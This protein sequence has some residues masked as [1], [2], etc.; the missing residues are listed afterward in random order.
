MVLKNVLITGG[1][2]YIGSNIVVELIRLGYSVHVID[3]LSNSHVSVLKLM[4]NYTQEK[5]PLW[6]LNLADQ[7][8]FSDLLSIFQCY[9]FDA[10]IHCAGKKF[11]SE[12]FSQ[13][14]SYYKTNVEGSLN[15][16]EAMNA[17]GVRNLIFSSSASIYDYEFLPLTRRKESYPLKPS[18]P[19]GNTKLVIENILKD[20]CMADDRWNIISLR[21]FN[22]VGSHLSRLFGES[23]NSSQVNLFSSLM[24]VA[25]G[26][27]EKLSVY[28]TDHSTPDGTGI[29]DYVHIT[30]LASAHITALQSLGK[31]SF[32]CL[33]YNVGTGMGWSV[34]DIVSLFKDILDI[35]V[36]LQFLPR[37]DGDPSSSIADPGLIKNDLGWESKLGLQ[38]MLI[39]H[40]EFSSLAN[41][42]QI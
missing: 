23:L 30:D 37:R 15:L 31:K 26:W 34:L 25:L 28:G 40:W 19:Y 14:L 10:V 20:V 4:E 1:L 13:P 39:D 9:S 38:Q 5:I 3:D 41:R 12:S 24:K 22:P 32:G 7:Q 42:E 11:P 18:S 6:E 35:D 36:P 29:R 21:Y 2:G 17:F 8:S 16:L 33:A 27:Q